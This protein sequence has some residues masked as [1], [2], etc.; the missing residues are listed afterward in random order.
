MYYFILCYIP[1][2]WPFCISLISLGENI[3]RGLDL[4]VFFPFFFLVQSIPL[5][6]GLG[7]GMSYNL[8]GGEQIHAC[9]IPVVRRGVVVIYKIIAHRHHHCR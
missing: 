8:E 3:C 4:G 9:I 2:F 7:D 6:R 1:S 5:V